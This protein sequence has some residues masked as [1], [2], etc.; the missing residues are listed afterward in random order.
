MSSTV[1]SGSVSGHH[2]VIADIAQI[3]IHVMCSYFLFMRK[4]IQFDIAF[5]YKSIG[6]IISVVIRQMDSRSNV[7]TKHTHTRTHTHAHACTRTH[8]H[9]HARNTHAS[10]NYWTSVCTVAIR[11]D[12]HLLSKKTDPFYHYIP[13]TLRLQNPQYAFPS[14]TCFSRH[15]WPRGRHVTCR[16]RSTSSTS[17]TAG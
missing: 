9:A 2:D 5:K 17:G 7:Y 14:S 13:G 10:G 12:A 6:T 15:P 1:P 16:S 8:A 11:L 3:S 4:S